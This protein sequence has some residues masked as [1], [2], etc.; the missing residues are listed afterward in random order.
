MPDYYNSGTVSVA[1]GATT[2]TGSLVLWSTVRSGDTLELAGQ[3]VTIASVTDTSHLELAAAWTG[4][5]QSGATYNIRYDAP[6]RFAGCD[7]RDQH[8]AS[9]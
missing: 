8:S 6:A 7:H 2:V 1:S 9:P 3:R 5:S 4:A